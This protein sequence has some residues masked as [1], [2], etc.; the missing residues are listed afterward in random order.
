MDEER[1]FLYNAMYFFFIFLFMLYNKFN[2]NI[3]TEGVKKTLLL[4]SKI[5]EW[6]V[7]TPGYVHA[8]MDT[9]SIKYLRYW[10]LYFNIENIYNHNWRVEEKYILVIQHKQVVNTIIRMCALV[11]KY[12][13]SKWVVIAHGFKTFS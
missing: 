3:L 1:I 6:A 2:F 7:A 12:V 5:S 4:F 8:Y 9:K 11:R 13:K 10:Y